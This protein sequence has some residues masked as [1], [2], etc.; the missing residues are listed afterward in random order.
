MTGHQGGHKIKPTAFPSHPVD[1]V[2]KQFSPESCLTFRIEL[3]VSKNF[4][5]LFGS[6]DILIYR[7]WQASMVGYKGNY[8]QAGSGHI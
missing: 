8:T 1:I 4:K 7:T 2:S 5:V 3:S 6:K